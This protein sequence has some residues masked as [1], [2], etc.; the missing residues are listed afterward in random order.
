MFCFKKNNFSSEIEFENTLWAFLQKL[1]D[2]DDT[3]WDSK[4]SKNPDDFDFSFSVKGKA[5]YILGMY[6]GSSRLA[7][8][9][10]YCTVVFNLHCQFEKLRE[11][12]V[13]QSVKRK[14]RKRDKKLQGHINSVLK[15]FGTAS[16]AKQYSG[17]Q[18]EKDWKCPFNQKK[19]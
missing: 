16:E 15:D 12:G 10:P 7:R 19:I 17:R 5:F 2:Q 18:I 9:A 1:H 14:I 11:M 3:S 6:P 8:R 13:Y 4:V